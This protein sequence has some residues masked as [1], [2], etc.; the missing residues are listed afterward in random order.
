LIDRGGER[1]PLAPVHAGMAF[2]ACA[3]DE[4]LFATTGFDGRVHLRRTSDGA[5]VNSLDHG[6]FIFSVS[7]SADGRRLLTAGHDR[8]NLWGPSSGEHLW[9]GHALGIG[10]HCWAALSDDGALAVA[11]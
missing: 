3:V 11:V 2:A 7:G 5:L 1:R 9:G 8:L 6:G 10:L 4:D